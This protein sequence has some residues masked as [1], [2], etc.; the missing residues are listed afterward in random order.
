[1][2]ISPH[3][4]SLVLKGGVLL[5]AYGSRRPTRDIDFQGQRLSNDLSSML[6]LVRDIA[7]V[8]ANDGLRFLPGTAN[9]ETIREGDNYQGV[10][11][12][13]RASIATAEITF[14]VDINV[15]DPI[16]P[17]PETVVLPGLLGRDVHLLG[18]PLAMVHAEKIV[19]AIDRG[20][21]NTRW[22]D[23]AD[24]HTLCGRHPIRGTDLRASLT[25]VAAH[26]EVRLVALAEVL[27]GW[28]GVAQ[29]KWLAWRR[30][31]QLT[32]QLPAT[33][34]EVLERVIG[35]ADPVI[36]D[37]IRPEATWDPGAGS[38]A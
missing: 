26:R 23:F 11:V 36:L 35:F 24:V 31:Q 20:Q 16:R 21:T 13:L 37:W 14:H 38:W 29:P 9:A 12:S 22:R 2:T 7:D 28:S 19:T 25:G 33:F 1:M 8:E 27:A 6:A 32:G 4:S 34:D 15:G 10:R 5:A 17:A 30:K 3:A 18:Y